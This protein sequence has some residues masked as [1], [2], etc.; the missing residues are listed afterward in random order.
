MV[1]E[2]NDLNMASL[3][4]TTSKT[5]PMSF[6][7]VLSINLNNDNY[8]MCKQQ[9]MAAIRG[10]NLLHFIEASSRSPKFSLL[11]MKIQQT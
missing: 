2:Y 6:E 8:L 1:L 5:N 3:I 11:K 10:H 4:A 7:K 9:M